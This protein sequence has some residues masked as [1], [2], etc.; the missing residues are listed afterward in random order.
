MEKH[1]ILGRWA[2]VHKVI[3]AQTLWGEK[4]TLVAIALEA[5]PVDK[6]VVT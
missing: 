3:R 4:L 6:G 2:L 5:R 1:S